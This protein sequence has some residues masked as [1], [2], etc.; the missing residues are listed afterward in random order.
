MPPPYQQEDIGSQPE[1]E[2]RNMLN[3]RDGHASA[4]FVIPQI[5]AI[6]NADSNQATDMLGWMFLFPKKEREDTPAMRQ[7]EI[8][9]LWK[10]TQGGS[11]VVYLEDFLPPGTI[12]PKICHQVFRTYSSEHTIDYSPALQLTN[13]VIT[14]PPAALPISALTYHRDW[15]EAAFLRRSDINFL[16]DYLSAN[17]SQGYNDVFFSGGEVQYGTMH[18]PRLRVQQHNYKPEGSAMPLYNTGY[19][20][21]LKAEPFIAGRISN[22]DLPPDSPLPPGEDETESELIDKNGTKQAQATENQDAQ[23]S[24]EVSASKAPGA[25]MMIPCPDFW[26]IIHET[27]VEM[28]AGDVLFGASIVPQVGENLNPSLFRDLLKGNNKIPVADAGIVL[29]IAS[30]IRSTFGNTP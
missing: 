3:K 22:P 16:R 14:D 25:F 17:S 7:I 12:L 27:A 13:I 10:T 6:L 5:N 11:V 28:S 29:Q 23:E 20:F 30:F 1:A 26:D 21:T 2:L 18:N 4:G 15:A 8:K 24:Q 9:Q 19:A